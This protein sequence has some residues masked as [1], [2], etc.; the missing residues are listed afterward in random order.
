MPAPSFH[1]D[2]HKSRIQLASNL[3][4]SVIHAVL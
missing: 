2:S 3:A 4:P 1:P